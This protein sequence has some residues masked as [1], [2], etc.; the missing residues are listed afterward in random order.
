M[1]SLEIERGIRRPIGAAPR[2]PCLVASAPPRELDGGDGSY[3]D[4]QSTRVIAAPLSEGAHDN[5]TGK[6][7]ANFNVLSARSSTCGSRLGASSLILLA[8]V[9]GE[10]HD[11]DEAAAAAVGRGWKHLR[12]VVGKVDEIR[13]GPSI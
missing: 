6:S 8:L 12:F 3:G 7:S 13:G 1:L 10:G 9:T 4:P 11:V 5:E 2:L